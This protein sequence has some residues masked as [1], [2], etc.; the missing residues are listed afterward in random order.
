M[1]TQEQFF[2]D[3]IRI[4]LDSRAEKEEEFEKLQQEKREKFKPSSTS[5][6]NKEE[7]RV[8]E[9]EY[10]KFVKFQDKEMENFVAEEE[11][12]REA[13]KDNI[14]AMERRHWEEKVQLEEKFN[15]ELVKLMEKY[16]LS[17]PETKSSDIW[18]LH[19]A[20]KKINTAK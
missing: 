11:K 3:Q 18:W 4:I 17:H 12:L 7:G 16:S 20:Y 1:Y 9:D 6:L 5:P 8:K 2:K 13:H 15:E 19:I 14:A 10:Q